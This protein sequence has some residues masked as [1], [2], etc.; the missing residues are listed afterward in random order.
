MKVHLNVTIITKM[1]IKKLHL[2]FILLF[3]LNMLGL[4]ICSVYCLAPP[5]FIEGMKFGGLEA[6]S[7]D[8]PE[9]PKQTPDRE[10]DALESLILTHLPIFHKLLSDIS[11]QRNLGVSEVLSQAQQTE[12]LDTLKQLAGESSDRVEDARKEA[13]RQLGSPQ[14]DWSQRV[15]VNF[16]RLILFELNKSL[17]VQQGW[18]IDIGVEQDYVM[19][20]Q[21]LRPV[22]GRVEK[23][24]FIDDEGETVI[25]AEV[26]EVAQDIVQGNQLITDARALFRNPG[27]VLFNSEDDDFLNEQYDAVIRFANNDETK[28]DFPAMAQILNQLSSVSKSDYRQIQRRLALQ[29]EWGHYKEFKRRAKLEGSQEGKV[30]VDQHIEIIFQGDMLNPLET[31]LKDHLLSQAKQWGT[32]ET[33]AHV[34]MLIA[35]ETKEMLKKLFSATSAGE[36]LVSLIEV[37]IATRAEEN[38]HIY[39]SRLILHAIEEMLQGRIAPPDSKKVRVQE[40][41]PQIAQIGYEQ[42]W[43]KMDELGRTSAG[44]EGAVRLSFPKGGRQRDSSL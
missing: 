8:L 31:V 37:I 19:G 17:F 4:Q 38:Q 9:W 35:Y 3:T 21:F 16:A 15:W 28:R 25:L 26:K 5:G 1:H 42:L 2:L 13:I 30:T 12:L 18:I 14:D 36:F 34:L 32:D 11:V 20:G 27:Y 40:D 43:E 7:E 33:S 39:S 44:D 23:Y 24:D 22:R 41:F 6:E 29:E 10:S